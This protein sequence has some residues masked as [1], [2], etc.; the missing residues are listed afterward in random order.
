[1]AFERPDFLSLALLWGVVYLWATRR[2]SPR[3]AGLGIAG[4]VGMLA[5]H[6][7]EWRV[8]TYVVG[9]LGREGLFGLGVATTTLV[10]NTL[11][12]M[13][14]ACCLVLVL[15]AVMADRPPPDR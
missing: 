1:M 4:L 12:G 15:V 2:R 13:V 10:A 3:A 14:Y 7:G 11:L 9:R 5:M 6:L 8:L